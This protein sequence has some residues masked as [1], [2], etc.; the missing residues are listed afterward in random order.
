ME[1]INLLQRRRDKINERMK[2]LQKLVPNSNKV[3]MK[4]VGLINSYIHNTKI[5]LEKKCES[6]QSSCI[7]IWPTA[8]RQFYLVGNDNVP[9]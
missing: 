5:N 4:V 7:Y 6:L 8:Y 1:F 9:P 3:L 2:T